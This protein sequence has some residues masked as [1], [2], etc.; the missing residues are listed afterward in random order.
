VFSLKKLGWH[1]QSF[2][3]GIMVKVSFS[4]RASLTWEASNTNSGFVSRLALCLKLPR[5]F[6]ALKNKNASGLEVWFGQ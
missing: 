3:Y 4:L 6:D 1:L 2:L 5:H